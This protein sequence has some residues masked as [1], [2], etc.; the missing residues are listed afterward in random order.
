MLSKLQNNHQFK[1]TKEMIIL[2]LKLQN[3]HQIKPAKEI[4]NQQF[5]KE[6][7]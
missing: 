5:K 3:H 2:S 1:P 6:K 7:K 4:W